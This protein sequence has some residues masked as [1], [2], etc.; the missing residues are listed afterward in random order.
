MSPLS[1]ASLTALVT[2]LAVAL[3]AAVARTSGRRAGW[4]ALVALVVW[5]GGALA[6]GLSGALARAPG[7]APALAVPLVSVAAVLAVG[8]SPA[9]RRLALG[10]PLWALVGAQAFRVPLEIL[11]HRLYVEGVLPVQMTYAGANLDVVTGALAVPLAWALWRGA[12]SLARPSARR[13][14][15]AFNA[16]GVALLVVVVA[17]AVLSLPT[18]FRQFPAEPSTVALVTT[19]LV[20]LPSFL[21]PLAGLGHLL[22]VRRLLAER[23]AASPAPSARREPSAPGALV[24]RSS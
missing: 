2:V 13:A 23:R 7:P 10:V 12:G 22:V 15:A 16:L 9:G 17:L 3:L 6:L 19:P 1:L 14:T 20:W 24:P 4:A 11:L 21:V 8:L 5:L 18:P